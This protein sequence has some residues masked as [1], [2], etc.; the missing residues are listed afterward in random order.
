MPNAQQQNFDG[1]LL[2]IGYEYD[3]RQLAPGEPLGITLYWQALA[4]EMPDYEVQLR[5]L[6]ESGW[7]ME[8]LQER[9]LSGTSST[10][11]WAPGEIVV[12]RHELDINRDNTRHLP[13]AAGLAA[14]GQRNGP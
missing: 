14:H 13:R 2:L 12:D 7:I 1:D 8:T 10:A 4:D 3:Q 11:D 5:L 6:D 9:P